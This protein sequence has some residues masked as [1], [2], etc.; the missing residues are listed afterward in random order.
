MFKNKKELFFFA[1]MV[2]IF[3]LISMAIRNNNTSEAAEQINTVIEEQITLKINP[4]ENI[5][6][7]IDEAQDGTVIIISTGEYTI[8]EPIVIESRKNLIIQGDRDVWIFGNRVDFQIFM[9]RDSEN[10]FIKNIKACHKI[11]P[12]TQNTKV[13]PKRIGSVMDID[14]CKNVTLENCELEGCG[15]YGV[16]AVNTDVLNIYG[17]YL[18]HNSWR[19]LGLFNTGNVM[20]VVLRDCTI[21]NNADFLEKEG[22][23]HI[24]FEGKNV[25]KDNTY[26]K[27]K[28]TNN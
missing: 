21:I 19:A 15:V 6:Q 16:Y 28:T 13:D 17:C 1:L 23:I 18:H 12:K 10:I 11:G 26:E 8:D 22:N 25:I 4:G 20:N 7:K 24:Q 27:Y 2:I 14:C 3:L 9:I 5:Q